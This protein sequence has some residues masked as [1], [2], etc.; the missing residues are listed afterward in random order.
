M[1]DLK[2][3]GINMKIAPADS[4]FI[5][6]SNSINQFGDIYTMNVNNIDKTHNRRN[7]RALDFFTSLILLA[8]YPFIFIFLKNKFKMLKNIF[9]VLFN[10][11]TWVG[12][13]ETKNNKKLPYLKKGVFSVLNQ[14]GNSPNKPD[15]NY[16][17]NLNIIY[18]RDYNIYTDIKIIW[19]K[20]F[21]TSN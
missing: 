15:S 3:T 1:S 2:N 11:K 21:R 19:K 6:G 16:I 8:T 13:E 12:Y 17:H 10:L 9:L 7:K 20:I 5:I 4:V 14:F 18:A